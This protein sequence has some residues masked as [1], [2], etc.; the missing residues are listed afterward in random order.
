[1]H[2]IEIPVKSSSFPRKLN[3]PIFLI[4]SVIIFTQIYLLPHFAQPTNK[5]VL[6]PRN[7]L[8]AYSRKHSTMG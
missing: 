7:S 8:I 5:V 1:M 4:C 2:K 6:K 3:F